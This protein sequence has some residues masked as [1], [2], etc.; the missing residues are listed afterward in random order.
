LITLDILRPPPPAYNLRAKKW[1]LRD[2]SAIHLN[3]QRSHYP[4]SVSCKV[5]MKV[6]DEVMMTDD[7]TLMWYDPETC[8]WK[9]DG[10][11]DFQYTETNKTAQFYVTTVGTFA[12]VK[13]RAND[14]PYRRWSL[15]PIRAP[16]SSEI[17]AESATRFSVMTQG[18]QEVVIDIIGTK[19]KLI[20]PMNRQLSDLVNV[21]LT[22]GV[23]LK[24]LAKRGLNLLPIPQS[25]QNAKKVRLISFLCLCLSACLCLSLSVS[26]STLLS[27]LG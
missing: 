24:S 10:I 21:E 16:L 17:A 23:L 11:S 15:T 4:S 13:D 19:V 12:L 25:Q 26:L 14:F 6:P 3:L 7:I 22:M 27:S 18:S 20:R 8:S 2:K 5:L 1:I 9:S